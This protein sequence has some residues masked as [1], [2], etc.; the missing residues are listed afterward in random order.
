MTQRLDGVE[1]EVTI[2][3]RPRLT[4]PGP[5]DH[6]YT[7]G[8][9]TIVGGAMP[10][11]AA[12]A[13][14]AAARAGAG[15]V[16]LVARERIDRLPFAI[17]QRTGLDAAALA[18]LLDDARIGAIVVGMGLGRDDAAK[19][20]VAS[21]FAS[22]R[23][24]VLDAD[25]LPH[26]AWPLERPAILTPHAGEFARV[27]PDLATHGA[28]GSSPSG[29]RVQAA[30]AAA[31]QSNAIVILKGSETVIA[32]PD[33]CAVTAPPACAGLATAGTGDVLAGLC[34][35]MLAQLRDPFAAACA[36]VWLHARSAR[37]RPVPFIADDLVD[38]A[39][40]MAVAECLPAS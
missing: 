40:P 8:F 5:E 28:K 24:L 13:T 9:V 35:T 37:D 7:R 15:Y 12:L 10:G 33:G 1:G 16:Q 34:G 22:G 6:K 38:G 20:T 31:R 32:G 18:R 36:A 14:L 39:L 27:F 26:V 4:A 11:A 2:L 21:A 3:E 23:P 19:V 25:A 29:G 30:V 17:V